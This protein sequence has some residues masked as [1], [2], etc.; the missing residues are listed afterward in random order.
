MDE[1]KLINLVQQYTCL[2]DISSRHYSDRLMKENAW[3]AI[4]TEMGIPGKI[5]FILIQ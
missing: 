1:E 2:Y 3:E 4:N 5:L